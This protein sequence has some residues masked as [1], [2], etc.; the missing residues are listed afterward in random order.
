MEEETDAVVTFMQTT[1]TVE[2][3]DGNGGTI[4]RMVQ[5]TRGDLKNAKLG[6]PE[7][8]DGY[9]SKLLEKIGKGAV[10]TAQ[11]LT[12][13]A[14]QSMVE[15]IPSLEAHYKDKW[16]RS[17]EQSSSRSKETLTA[18]LHGGL[19][20]LVNG[21]TSPSGLEQS[22]M[23]L[24][25]ANEW[26]RSLYSDG[27]VIH[28]ESEDTWRYF[29]VSEKCSSDNNARMRSNLAQVFRSTNAASSADAPL[30]KRVAM[31]LRGLNQQR[32]EQPGAG[33]TARLEQDALE[34][35]CSDTNYACI[36]FQ[37]FG[38]ALRTATLVASRHNGEVC[39]QLPGITN[40]ASSAGTLEQLGLACCQTQS[41][42]AKCPAAR[43]KDLVL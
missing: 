6:A 27:V 34:Q 25:G 40:T 39:S 2:Q 15:E 8:V 19:V 1:H 28:S 42:I 11:D 9:N 30:E 17:T 23:E 10:S 21:F 7:Q 29:P 38:T 18:T 24:V 12:A 13:M 37:S 41:G 4:S 16:K 3:K 26:S 33:G 43:G 36:K 31:A 22:S 14:L 5:K 20:G 35:I 32:Q